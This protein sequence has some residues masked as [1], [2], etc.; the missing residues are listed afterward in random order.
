MSVCETYAYIHIH[1][2]IQ[3]RVSIQTACVQGGED[4][5]DALSCRLF[6]AKEPLMMR[7]ITYEDKASYDSMPPCMDESCD[8]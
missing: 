1:S 3:I 6:F 5:Q 8:I 2:Y 7:K 4:P